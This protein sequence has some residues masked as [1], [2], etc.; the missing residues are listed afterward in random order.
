MY[1]GNIYV[2]IVMVGIQITLTKQQQK[3][4]EIVYCYQILGVI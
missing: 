3:I 1:F 4:C 2:P